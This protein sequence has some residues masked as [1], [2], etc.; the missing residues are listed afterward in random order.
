MFSL[1]KTFTKHPKFLH[2]FTKPY[3]QLYNNFATHYTTSQ[4]LYKHIHNFYKTLLNLF[5]TCKNSTP[6]TT[7]YTTLQQFTA[8]C[9]T[10]QHFCNTLHNFTQ[11]YTNYVVYM[12]W[13]ISSSWRPHCFTF[14]AVIAG[15]AQ[16]RSR[17]GCSHWHEVSGHAARPRSRI[18]T[19]RR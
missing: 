15:V 10:L 19:A 9:T 8:L 11:L 17:L 16:A 2:S 7:L 14:S 4:Q 13:Q 1:T 3:R 18:E 12:N 5:K 6:N